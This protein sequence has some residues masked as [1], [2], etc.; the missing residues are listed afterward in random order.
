MP[1]KLV[2]RAG[3]GIFYS[4]EDI[5][6]SDIDLAANPPN[7]TPVT[8]TA[9]TGGK[10]VLTLSQPVPSNILT[11]S[12]SL[13]NATAR[14]QNYHA[15]R[16]H[17]FNVALQYQLP[18]QSTFELAYVGNRGYNEPAE[19]S[20]NQVNYGLD[21]SI[22]ANRPYPQWAGVQVGT[23][24][25]RSWYNSLQAK[26]EKRLTNGWYTLASYT[27]ASAIDQA[28]AWGAGSSPVFRNNFAA[29]N[30]PQSQ[31]ARHNFTLSDVYQLPF[32]R[33]R[34]FGSNWNRVV[35]GFL[36]GWQ[37]SN[38]FTVRTG[39]PINVSL[40][41]SGVNP[42]TNQ[43][44]KF[45]NMNGG[46]YRPNIVGDPNTGISPEVN[47]NDFLSSTAFQVQ[48]LNTPGDASRDV[49]LGPGLFNLDLSL[50][51][52]FTVNDRMS[53]DIRGDAFNS[54]NRVNFGNPGTTFGSSTFGVISTAGNPR[55]MQ[56]AVRF[57][58]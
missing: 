35:D 25:A 16:I 7:V 52:R 6:G 43:S 55:I 5:S 23:T 46:S 17:Q 27:F 2:L 37:I 36:G 50:T 53:F 4:G 32:G 54:T 49:A 14:E 42:A 40:S 57:Q 21:G 11:S 45:F 24:T 12:T 48:P 41:T 39:L 8:L 1:N 51:K 9:V 34:H 26:F 20:G 31:T 58:F 13:L 44:Y 19:Y 30:G 22:P 15:A 10:P 28:G 29:E 33:G 47:R 18:K 38:I 56:L 3:Y